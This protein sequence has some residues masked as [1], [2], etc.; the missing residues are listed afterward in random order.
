MVNLEACQEVVVKV[1]F[2]T[3]DCQL[4][5]VARGQAISGGRHRPRMSKSQ[6]P[7]VPGEG[8]ICSW[9]GDLDLHGLLSFLSEPNHFIGVL[10]IRTAEE[11]AI[12]CFG[13]KARLREQL[14]QIVWRRAMHF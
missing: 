7:H 14:F 9:D 1:Q 12:D 3:G 13:L 5:T 8:V 6:P 4:H 11:V 10:V 2:H